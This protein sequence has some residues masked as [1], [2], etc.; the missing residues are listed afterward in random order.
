MSVDSLLGVHKDPE[1]TENFVHIRVQDPADFVDG[2]FRTITISENEGI[3][4]VIGKLKS[5]PSGSTKVQKFIFD[6]SKG[7]TM[8]KAQTW[9]NQH[10]NDKMD[11][12]WDT[13]YVNDLNDSAFAVIESGGKK[14][15]Q[16]KTVP[17]ELRH[18]EHH[19]AEGNLDET[20]VRNALQQLDKTHISAELK[21]E[22]LRHLCRHA[23]ELGIQSEKCQSA[24]DCLDPLVVLQRSRELLSR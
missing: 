12:I 14:D 15:D 23:K 19:N 6:K 7:W 21:A 24:N 5:D 10:K 4:A 13:K 18:L 8:E 16:G 9:V 17:R 3:K 1:E 2:S 20:H 22:A 11:A